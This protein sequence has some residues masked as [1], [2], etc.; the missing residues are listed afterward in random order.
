MSFVDGLDPRR[1]AARLG[2][3]SVALRALRDG[4]RAER[5]IR[6]Y[7]RYQDAHAYRYTDGELKRSHALPARSPGSYRRSLAAVTGGV[8]ALDAGL[9]CEQPSRDLPPLGFCWVKARRFAARV[10]ADVRTAVV[11]GVKMHMRVGVVARPQRLS[12]AGKQAGD[13]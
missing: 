10:V 13:A 5:A 7:A 1:A 12:H 9:R 6:A 4:Q 11:S 3:H 8:D 2:P